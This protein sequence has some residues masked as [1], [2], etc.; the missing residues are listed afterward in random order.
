MEGLERMAENQDRLDARLLPV[1]SVVQDWPKVNVTEISA[2]YLRQGQSVQISNAP[3]HG[4]VGIFMDSSGL[5]GDFV[6]V[7]E[8]TETGRVA[9]RRLVV[10]D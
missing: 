7:G 2:F 10:N 3:T 5:N 4:W 8:V 1:S 9:P 6:G